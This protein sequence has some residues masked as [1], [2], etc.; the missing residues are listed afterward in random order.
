MKRIIFLPAL[1]LCFSM[2]NAESYD[3]TVDEA[4]ELA[5]QNN[6]LL[7]TKEFELQT[8]ERA[9]NRMWNQFVPSVSFAP[10]FQGNLMPDEASSS[11]VPAV[12][13][14]DWAV[15][16][17]ISASLPLNAAM[18]TGIK[19]TQKDFHNGIISYETA[20]AQLERDVKKS[21]YNLVFLEQMIALFEQN[22]QTAESRFIQAKVKFDNGYLPRLQM[23]TA[24]A[25][26]ENLKP[27][28][29]GQRHLY[30]VS[31]M[32]FKVYLGLAF[33]DEMILSENGLI[34]HELALDVD[35][36]IDTNLTDRLD[37]QLLMGTLDYLKLSKT[38]L[39]VGQLSPSVVFGVNYSA[40]QS[41]YLEDKPDDLAWN[42]SATMTIGFSV[43]IDQLIPGSK[44]W[45]SAEE[46][47]DSIGSM[48]IQLQNALRMA[49]LEIR[50]KVMNIEKSTENIRSLEFNVELNDLVYK[51]NE[52]GYNVGTI[53][54]LDL[55]SAEDDLKQA[56]INLISEK[57]NYLS[58]LAD[59]EYAVNQKLVDHEESKSEK[60][61]EDEK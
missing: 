24:Q 4:V 55:E 12:D 36:L 10:G 19:A 60:G 28:L 49:E 16:L 57:V 40:R 38:T 15:S 47:Q 50:S 18:F 39:L 2:L 51:D 37:I 1:L 3:I 14:P 53:D 17:G 61:V 27:Q 54:I 13:L 42:D 23:L 11:M 34:I 46:M 43:P 6:L 58:T 30:K 33:A 29:I 26:V 44:T 7:K 31:M 35:N 22:L 9:K 25:M 45:T 8:K 52:T 48:E 20:V 21:Y 59:L 56:K 41:I 32:N 5:V